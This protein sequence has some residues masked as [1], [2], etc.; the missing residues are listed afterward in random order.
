MATPAELMDLARHFRQAGDVTQAEH[1]YRQVLQGDPR[2]ANAHCQ[3]GETLQG[4]GRWE[5][6]ISCFEQAIRL[7]P[8]RTGALNNLGILL[9]M[10]RRFAEAEACFQQALRIDPGDAN[11]LYNFGIVLKAQG[12]TAEASACFQQ[13]TRLDT[14]HAYAHFN[15]GVALL[16]LGLPAEAA[17]AHRQALRVQPGLADAHHHLG[18]ALYMG[19]QVTDA[20]ACYRT[21]LHLNPNLV[22]AHYNLGN[23]LEELGQPAE[24]IESYRH[25]LGLNPNRADVY[26]NLGNAL[27]VLDRLDEAADCF[28]QTL[29]IDPAYVDAY[30]HLANACVADGRFE[31]AA[32]FYRQALELDSQHSLTLWNQTHLRLL[33]GDLEGGWP[34]YEQRWFRPGVVPRSFP[35]PRWDGTSLRGKT[36]FIYAEQGLGD[37]LQFVRYLSMVGRHGGTVVFECQPLL[38]R[39]LAG[40]VGVA[41]IIAAGEPLPPFDV[42]IPLL[43]LPGLFGTNIETIPASV[44]YL[45]VDAAKAASWRQVLATVTGRLPH[46]IPPVLNIGIVWQGSMKLK[47]DRRS[48]P[49]AAFAPLARLPGV[50]LLSLQVGPARQQLATAPFSIADVGSRFDLSSLE[51]LAAVLMNLDLVVTVDTAVAHLAGALGMPVWVVLPYSACWRWLLDRS[52]SPWYPSMRL[53]RQSVR[54]D[55]GAVFENVADALKQRG[56]V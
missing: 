2:N 50:R 44:P 47:G 28:R 31:E 40:V 29:L 4:T 1:L 15:L 39:L 17:A 19:G 11:A 48:V 53:F 13:V 45:L 46:Q 9:V 3:L 21:A 43:S 41:R 7:D 56:A 6:A 54:G 38:T 24:A 27:A 52:D 20:G 36:L 35:Q 8:S 14:D 49:L 16:E 12:R 5:E 33:Q 23:V 51:D 30:T 34:G 22:D 25:A 18:N 37:T 42:Q 26:N 10:Q 55:W 32:S